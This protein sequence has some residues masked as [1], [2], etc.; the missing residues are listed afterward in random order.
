[1]T[2]TPTPPAA[3]PKSRK[4]RIVLTVFASI[5]LVLAVA[6]GVL[7]WMYGGATSATTY[8]DPVS[9]NERVETT[10]LGESLALLGLTDYFQN[11]SKERAFVSY[12]LPGASYAMQNVT[13]DGN[14]TAAANLT[15]TPGNMSYPRYYQ[16]LVMGAALGA[17]PSSEK[18]E[19]VQL[20]K[21]EP[22][23]HWIGDRATWIQLVKEGKGWTAFEPT[24]QQRVAG[25]P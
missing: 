6:T 7:F 22:T 15:V 4:G 18:I 24:V 2:T 8:E 16:L 17:A 11:A 25:V 23:L 10:A 21:G 20:V 1:M 12:E 9:M 14:Y 3:K 5:F 13:A 19:V